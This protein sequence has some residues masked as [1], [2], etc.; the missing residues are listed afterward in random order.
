MLKMHRLSSNVEGSALARGTLL[1]IAIAVLP[2]KAAAP[3]DVSRERARVLKGANQYLKEAP[4]TITASRAARSAGGPHDYFSEGDYWWPDPKNPDGPYIQRDGESNP[5]NFDDHRKAMRRLSV[6][7]PALVAAWTLTHDGRYSQHAA[8]HLR[9]WFVTPA[10]RMNP[11]LRYSQAIHGV[12]T[13]RSIGIIDTIH[14][15]EVARA[16]ER[17]DGAPGWTPEDARAVRGWFAEYLDW[18]T[19][20]RFGIQERDATNNHGTCWVM[21]AAAFAHLTGNTAV[22]QFT[23]DRFKTVLIPNHMAADGS[24]PR[25]LG[26]TKPYGYSLFNLDAMA[27]IAEILSTPEDNLWMFEL[28]DGRG[29]K[30]AME[31][32]VPFI[33]NKK[34]WPKPPDVMY[35]EAWPMRQPSLLFAGLALNRPDYLQLWSTLPADSDVDEVVRNFFIRQPLLW[36]EVPSRESRVP[37]PQSRVANAVA[38]KSPGGQLEMD[39]WIDAASALRY[40]VALEGNAVIE[41][42]AAGIV[43]DGVNLGDGAQRIGVKRSTTNREYPARGVHSVAH[44]RSNDARIELRHRKSG[45]PFALQVRVF[46]DGV[47]FRYVVPGTGARTPDEATLFHVPDGSTTWSHDLHGHY[48]GLYVKRAI[49]EVPSG[50]WAAPPLTFK[51]P[52]NTGYAS[53][54]EAGLRGYAGMALQADGR[55]TYHARLAHDH[56]VSYPY[57]LRYPPEAVQRLANAARIS[58]PIETPWRVVLAGRDLNVLVNADVIH[59]VSRPPDPALFPQGQATS[60]IRPGRAVWRYLDGGDNTYEGLKQFTEMAAELGFEHHVVEGLWRQWTPAQL[61]AFVDHATARHVGIWLWK[62]SRELHQ[63]AAR[64]AFFTMCR[65]IGV[66]GVK[67]DFLDHEAKEVIDYYE[68]ILRDAAEFHLMVDF[69]GANK[70]T[71]GDR[72]WPNELTRE[73]IYGFEHKNPGPWGPHDATV[74]FTRDLAGPADFTP[75]VF[76]D[77]RKETSWAHQIATAVIFTSPLLVYGGHPRSLLDNPAVDMIKSIP[78][79]WDETVVLP[80]SEIGEVAALARRHGKDWFVG[81]VNGA[82]PRTL[83]I[84]PTFLGTGRYTSLVVR[85]DPDNPAAVRVERGDRHAPAPLT[86]A[87]RE[88]GGFVARFT[89][90]A[91]S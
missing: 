71:G 7:V 30:R 52:G 76:G 6:Q 88:G 66:T 83:S 3:V 91:G 45:T 61:K 38:I 84:A 4:V 29:M 49:A 26:R 50:D 60:W 77:R 40:S 25:E 46:D 24:F 69:H 12:T 74:P 85:D 13:G 8:K 27:T 57:A 51:L 43:V 56:P 79:V 21:Q 14:L 16:V 33:R 78:S 47:A 39:V 63:P 15:V 72:T 20:D 90:E 48:E 53:I 54:T 1:L 35:D 68:A 18:L 87:L 42:S 5:A 89:P 32:M 9:A 67:I 64:R 19:T 55:G 65:D 17:L 59:N 86:I 34:G 10:T 58:G 73:G 31:F 28:P 37:S 23:R 81:V 11:N 2:L 36:V 70:P 80:E 62:H 22:Q 82:G 41:P 44:D 75:V